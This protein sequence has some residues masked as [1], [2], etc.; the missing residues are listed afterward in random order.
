MRVS[1][2]DCLGGFVA[3]VDLPDGFSKPQVIT[4]QDCPYVFHEGDRYKL[5]NGNFI[6]ST[7]ERI[8]KIASILNT[9]RTITI[10]STRWSSGVV[11]EAKFSATVK[12]EIPWLPNPAKLTIED[13]KAIR[14]TGLWCPTLENVPVG[15]PSNNHSEQARKAANDFCNV[16]SVASK[17]IATVQAI[18]H[19]GRLV[20]DLDKVEPGK[21]SSLRSHLLASGLFTPATWYRCRVGRG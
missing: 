16:R 3:F 11:A 5:A 10:H 13:S 2:F 1:L 19:E 7:S 8:I 18:D 20:C 17:L 9:P 6:S 14:L 12:M 15:A 4:H 21:T